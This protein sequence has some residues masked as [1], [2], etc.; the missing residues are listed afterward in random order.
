MYRLH[1]ASGLFVMAHRIAVCT[2]EM[3]IICLLCI[4]KTIAP[5][6]LHGDLAS[7]NVPNNS[8]GFGLS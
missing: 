6:L 5:S 7:I 1:V 8:D 2:N 4:F 3:Y